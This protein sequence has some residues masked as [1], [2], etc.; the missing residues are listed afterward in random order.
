MREPNREGAKRR[1]PTRGDLVVIALL[2]L[3]IPASHRWTRPRG[4]VAFLE[5]QSQN[6]T[7]RLEA[8]RDAELDVEGPVGRTRV[9]LVGR[10][11]WIERAPCRNRLCQ[12]MGRLRAPGRSLVCIP[13]KVVVRFTGTPEP[14]ATDAI[15]R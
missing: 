7:Q 6:G 9:R 14:G 2:V 3:L 8:G 13:N 4:S 10:T 1:V 11:A 15:T 12:R 5:V